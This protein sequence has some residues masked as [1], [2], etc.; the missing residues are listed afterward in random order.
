[1]HCRMQVDKL[2]CKKPALERALW[3]LLKGLRSCLRGMA[4]HGDLRE[5]NLLARYGQCCG[6]AWAE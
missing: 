5:G 2:M 6:E 3:K 4:V 1:M